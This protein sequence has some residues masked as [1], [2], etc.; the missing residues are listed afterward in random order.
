[1]S[2]GRAGAHFPGAGAGQFRAMISGLNA[3][4]WERDPHTWQMRFVNDR[5]VEVLGYPVAAW[6]AE[7]DLWPRSID[8]EDRE[9]TLQEVRRQVADGGEDFS[10]TY[11]ARYAD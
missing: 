7:P 3:V 8:A 9:R 1:M 4:V 2:G 5:I 11:R 10:L 6:L